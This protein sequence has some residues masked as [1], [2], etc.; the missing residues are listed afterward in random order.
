MIP[1]ATT[2]GNNRLACKGTSEKANKLP[3]SS[4]FLSPEQATGYYGISTP[5]GQDS[6]KAM[7]PRIKMRSIQKRIKMGHCQ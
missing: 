3:K 7:N 6:G 1:A 4:K 5:S 2:K